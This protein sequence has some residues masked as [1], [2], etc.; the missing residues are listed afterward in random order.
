MESRACYKTILLPA[1]GGGR[2]S[3][4]IAP[5]HSHRKTNDFIYGAF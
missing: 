5:A 1:A 2:L 4:A 3:S